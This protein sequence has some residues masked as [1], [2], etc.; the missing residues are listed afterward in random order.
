MGFCPGSHFGY[1]KW[2]AKYALALR[3]QMSIHAVAELTGLHWETVKNIEKSHLTK[4][5]RY[6]PLGA[7]RRLGIDEVYLGRSSRFITVVRDLDRGTVLFIGK[8]KGARLSTRLRSVLDARL[9]RSKRSPSTCQMP[10]LHG[11]VK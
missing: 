3:K 5:Y 2:L 1:T 8:G 7:V 4:K 9:R 11:S 6:V 10:M